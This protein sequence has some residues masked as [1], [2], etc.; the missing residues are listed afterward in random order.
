MST[1]N[2]G[3]TDTVTATDFHNG[4][5]LFF[6]HMSIAPAESF[7]NQNDNYVVVL[8][9]HREKIY[10]L[11]QTANIYTYMGNVSRFLRS[12]D[13]SISA[14]IPT[15]ATNTSA[16][17]AHAYWSAEIIEATF[18]NWNYVMKEM[19]ARA[20][21]CKS[22]KGFR[23]PPAAMNI[24]R[25]SHTQTGWCRFFSEEKGVV[26]SLTP[27]RRIGFQNGLD[28]M[29]RNHL[30]VN[31][32]KDPTT[33]AGFQALGAKINL[34]IQ[35][36][37]G[38]VV[39]VISTFTG[40]NEIANV[41]VL[42]RNL[43]VQASRNWEKFMSRINPTNYLDTSRQVNLPAAEL[44]TL[45]PNAGKPIPLSIAPAPVTEAKPEPEKQHNTPLTED[46]VSLLTALNVAS[47]A[48][49]PAAS[50]ESEPIKVSVED[51]E[52]SVLSSLSAENKKS[53]SEIFEICSAAGID[54]DEACVAFANVLM[55][56]LICCQ[57]FGRLTKDQIKQ[58]LYINQTPNCGEALMFFHMFR[59]TVKAIAKEANTAAV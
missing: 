53:A 2:T 42:V 44:P 49:Q 29:I 5:P 31:R 33:V 17:G 6:A 28:Y 21:V 40:K 27:T 45:P 59:A 36:N 10:F 52:N 48:K 35:T 32:I 23:A 16:R 38:V 51:I 26:N 18:D 46:A 58:A 54:I 14:G 1:I 15:G 47:D 4:Q 50:V 55:N 13:G 12:K 34:A 7:K 37:C 8:I 20:F 9:N 11:G 19:R 56:S 43:N 25:I 39:E 30:A 22:T 57:F 3:S 24:T 41:D